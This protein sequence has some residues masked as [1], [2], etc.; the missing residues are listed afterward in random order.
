MK[1]ARRLAL[2]EVTFAVVFWGA[3]FVGTKIALR[4]LA[5]V[6]VVWLRFAMGVLVLGGAV[7]ARGQFVRPSRKDLLY[8]AL[9]GFLGITFHQ[10]LQSNALLTSQATTS[11]WIVATTPVFIALL[12]WLFLQEQLGPVRI[13]GIVLAA[14]GVLL[15]VTR[16]DLNS[17]ELGKFGAPGDILVLVSAVNW[18]VFT[19][20]SRP[21]LKQHPAAQMML[22][23]MLIGWLFTSALFLAG[24]T[25]FGDIRNLS[26]T[27][28][29]GVGFLGIFCS[30]FAY[31]FWFDA[32]K[33]VDASQI[34]VFLYF[35]PLVTVVV[36]AALL[37]E[38]LGLAVALGGAIILLG[39]WLVNRP[40]EP[41]I[42]P[43]PKQPR[44]AP[45]R[46]GR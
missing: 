36:A 11:A 46:P 10:W 45:A 13:L 35:E 44:R 17:L 21:G 16:G 26:L 32:L 14:L 25:G 2:L 30:G 7:L 22:Y 42:S 5:P 23:V 41:V 29:V 9:L 1:S 12:S 33:Q 20:L 8:F 39:V 40:A 3:S 27:G 18:A 19:V 15:V 37:Q 43:P 28:W 38:S 34:G 31:I 4:E 24:P 6:T